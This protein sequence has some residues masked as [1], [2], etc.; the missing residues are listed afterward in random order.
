MEV[1]RGY[2]Q[3][4]IGVI[5]ED[6][7]AKSVREVAQIKTGPFGTLLKASEYSES[8]GVP[9]ISVGE[10]GAGKFEVTERTPLAPRAVIRRL[11]QYVLRTGDVVFGRKGAVERSALVRESEDGWFLGSDGM[12]IRPHKGCNPPYLAAQFQGHKVQSWLLNH[13]T[14]TTMA[15]LNQ[16]ILGRV[17][18]PVPPLR[19]QRAIAGALSDMDGLLDSMHRLIAKKRGLK[20]AVMQQLLTGRTRLPG[21][22]E[23]W[24][25]RRLAKLG[26]FLK[27]SGVKKD[28]ARS[29][30]LPCIRYGEIYTHHNDYVRA[31]NSWISREVASAATLLRRGDILFAG[32]GETKEEIGKCVAFVD[33]IEAYAGGD[34]VI[35]RPTGVDSLFLGYLLNTPAVASQKASQGQGDAVV[36]ISTSALASVNLSLPC[37]EEQTAIAAVLFDIDAELTALEARLAKTRNLKQAMMQE[38]LTGRVRLV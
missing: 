34:I 29:G 21:F 14:G 6:W 7:D 30:D 28:E 33:D 25:T 15:S 18:V 26:T 8:E 35:L 16:Q 13:A 3:T 19:E 20:Q 11:P 4:E 22:S 17:Q 37:L 10:I 1:R 9:L 31:F 32:S 36:H 24:E 12:A 5:P 27:G 2:K 23:E 38:L